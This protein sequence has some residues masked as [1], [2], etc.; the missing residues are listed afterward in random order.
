MSLGIRQLKQ[1]GKS[2]ATVGDQESYIHTLATDD[3]VMSA[4]MKGSVIVR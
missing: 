1:K 3:S 4:R 2:I